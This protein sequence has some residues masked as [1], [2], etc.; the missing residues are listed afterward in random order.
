MTGTNRTA[1]PTGTTAPAPGTTVPAAGA[2]AWT[3]LPDTTAPVPAAGTPVAALEHAARAR[4]PAPVFDFIAGGADDEVTVRR[5]VAAYERIGL[6][7]R[8]LRGAVPDL[9]TTLLG[10]P[11]S[12]PV[13]IAP[14]GM[15]KLAHPD[16]EIATARAAAGA[17]A[18]MIVSM[19]ATVAVEQ[20]A[21]AGAGGPGLWFQLFVQPDVDFTL[22]LVRRAE[23]AGCR[24]LVV[25]VDAA[26]FGNR[27]RDIRNGFTDLP[28]GLCCEHMRVPGDDGA[29][30][31]VRPIAFVPGLGWDHVA[32]LRD[33]TGLPIVLKGVMH[34]DDAALAIDRGIDGLIVSNHG[35]R[36][37]DGAAATIEVLAEV[38][39]AV[40]GRVPVL[41]DGGVRRGTDVVKAAALG[42]TA[43]GIG[44]PVLWG[45]A[46]AGAAGVTHV[47]ETMRAEVHR[48]LALCG[49]ATLADV[50]PSLVRSHAL[51]C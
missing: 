21:A 7:P 26:V 37:L 1:P 25:T 44:R 14:T 17:G 23:R 2:T 41:V 27:E 47:L 39:A 40:G 19:A 5:N 16:G 42:A 6:V 48:A 28:E 45:L 49:C 36:Q 43:V 15:H 12:L 8:V 22:S 11:T 46:V 20:I 9:S 18:L 31:H 3:A 29:P 10:T 32:R 30:G 35:G 34:P 38:A 51:P 13:V 4:L 50:G 24:A 33:A